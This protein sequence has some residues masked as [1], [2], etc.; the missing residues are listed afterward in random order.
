MSRRPAW[1]LNFL[2]IAWP[3]NSLAARATR[4]PVLGRLFALFAMPFYTGKNFNVSYI[5]INRDIEGAGST[6]IPL[7]VLDELIRRS[8]HRVIINRCTCRD[9]DN[10]KK[11]PI[12]DACLL[13]GE[14]TRHIDSRISRSVTM[15]EAITHAHSRV[16]MGLVP[17][18]GRVR[19][20][21]F[22]WGVPN[23]GQLLTI[24]FCCHCCCTIFKNARFF[25][26]KVADSLVPLRG[27]IIRTDDALCDRCGICV[28]GCFVKALSLEGGSIARDKSLCKGCGNCASIC[29][30]GAVSMSVDDV[31]AAVAEVLDRVE[32][33]INIR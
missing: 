32:R 12:E 8:A 16:E 6:T 14:G 9:S 19:V 18:I 21:D 27:L 24:C 5:P 20:D 13:M 23:N 3:L 28:E 4:L 10:C 25:P 1:W 17:M 33:L 29:P 22:Y 2:K 15:D 30:K 7:A 11:Y 26:G 31:D